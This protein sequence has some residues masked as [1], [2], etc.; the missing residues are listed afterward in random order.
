MKLFHCLLVLGV[1]TLIGC[2]E[3]SSFPPSSEWIRFNSPDA[4]YSVL[5]PGKPELVAEDEGGGDTVMHAC[6]LD[7]DQAVI[8]GSVDLPEGFDPRNKEKVSDMLDLGLKNAAENFNSKVQ[9]KKNL[10]IDRIYSARDCTIKAP[11]SDSKTAVIRIRLILIPG[12][13]IQVIVVSTE[14][15]S[16][17]PLIQKCLDSVKI[18]LPEE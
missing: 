12:K 16:A 8:T 11:I 3:K 15:E 5:M 4:P 10:I 6:K 14:A 7:A 2:G 18:K 1:L 13:M 17:N 9:N